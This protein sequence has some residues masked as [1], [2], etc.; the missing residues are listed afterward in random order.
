MRLPSG[1]VTVLLNCSNIS[2]TKNNQFLFWWCLKS[3]RTNRRSGEQITFR[4][5]TKALNRLCHLR[6]LFFS[7]KVCKEFLK[8]KK[9]KETK[10]KNEVHLKNKEKKKVKSK[11][12]IGLQR[13]NKASIYALN[14]CLVVFDNSGFC[15]QGNKHFQ[16]Q[17]IICALQKGRRKKRL[18]I[19]MCDACICTCFVCGTQAFMLMWK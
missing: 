11:I 18:F 16:L 8:K 5:T 7:G 15:C 19:L 9:R 4:Q 2:S 12:F 3:S 6:I 17:R 14:M 1:F 13:K 10:K